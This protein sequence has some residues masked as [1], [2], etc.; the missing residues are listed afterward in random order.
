MIQKFRKSSLTRTVMAGAA[1]TMAICVGLSGLLTGSAQAEI[2]ELGT[3]PVTFR[4]AFERSD[5]SLVV[6]GRT[7]DI[8]FEK[9]D[10][11]QRKAAN[12][13]VGL[14]RDGTL[15]P[16]FGDGGITL[17]PLEPDEIPYEVMSRPE[18]GF[19][20]V[21]SSRLRAY[22]ADGNLDPGFARSGQISLPGLIGVATSS[23]S[24]FTAQRVGAVTRVGKFTLAGE[25]DPE[26]GTEG[27]SEVP[28][29]ARVAPAVDS[30]ERVVLAG[31]D[32]AKR[33]AFRLDDEGKPDTTFG[34][35]GTGAADL[36]IQPPSPAYIFFE[37]L[38]RVEILAGDGVRVYFS[39]IPQLYS[40][41]FLTTDLNEDGEPPVPFP[42]GSAGNI[43]YRDEGPFEFL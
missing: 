6:T 3:E 15:I 12:L 34:T 23:S 36:V 38:Y 14:D 22:G 20:S 39:E 41:R 21:T 26:Y 33:Q 2:S 25:P 28:F 13:M 37:A 42:L 17:I 10:P 27:F 40:Q 31:E 1:S 5:G 18:G 11:D 7:G 43:N 35:H 29:E 30:K 24:I 19:L 8:L 4:D 32:G 16:D 9:D